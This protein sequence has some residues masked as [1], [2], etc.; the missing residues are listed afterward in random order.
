MHMIIFILSF[1]FQ[2][3][4]FVQADW[5]YW[6]VLAIVGILVV[7]G[8]LA[9]GQGAEKKK[10]AIKEFQSAFQLYLDAQKK[11]SDGGEKVTK[12]EWKKVTEALAE[13]GK[14]VFSIYRVTILEKVGALIK[15][16][17]K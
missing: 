8:L 9:K 11:D 6:A 2:A 3:P 13:A 17:F 12:E 16:I 1:F 5:M 14:N 15:K 4:D 7:W 10:E